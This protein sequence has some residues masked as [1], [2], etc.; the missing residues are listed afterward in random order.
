LLSTD[1]L[2][3]GIDLRGAS[4]IVHLDLPWN[5]A[6]LEQRV[7]RARRIGS[8]HPT[9]HV[10][11]FVPPAAAERMLRLERR[12]DAKIR[13]ARNVV[14]GSRLPLI[15][16]A[17]AHDRHSDSPIDASERVRS[18]LSAWLDP[19]A[20]GQDDAPLFAAA[21]AS[22]NGWLA[23]AY[24]DGLP[25]LIH[26]VEG[27]IIED[28]VAFGRRAAEL[29][30]AGAVDADARDDAV[31]RLERWIESRQLLA[32][33][34]VAG[35]AASATRLVLDRLS[36]CVARA[37][38]HRRTEI[39]AGAQRAR[40]GLATISGVGAERILA[41]LAQSPAADEAWIQS[42]LTFASLHA[43]SGGIARRS[44]IGA[45]ILA[46]GRV[47]VSVTAAAKAAPPATHWRSAHGSP[48]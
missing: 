17:A 26:C 7:G 15:P 39:L 33:I 20:R 21:D 1:L 48:R 19:V 4:V 35:S 5:P 22:F 13:I 36:R 25:R 28:P 31:S 42:V 9:I 23:V 2:S 45:I 38:R 47:P 3:E 27:V 29:G 40:D 30:D 6:R 18:G 32:D 41:D 34:G 12:L 37:P 8:R 24:V 43:S 10:Y 46:G 16:T 14:G 44:T 11:T